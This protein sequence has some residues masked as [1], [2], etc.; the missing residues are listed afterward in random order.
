MNEKP[1]HNILAVRVIPNELST[2]IDRL[3]EDVVL[4]NDISSC[5]MCAIGSCPQQVSELVCRNAVKAWLLAR[6]GEYLAVG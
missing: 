3:A 5:A 2:F 4:N 1:K 6:A